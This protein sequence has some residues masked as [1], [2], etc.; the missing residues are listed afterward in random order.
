MNCIGPD[1]IAAKGAE[2]SAVDHAFYPAGR[3][4]QAAGIAGLAAFL[5]GPDSGR[6]TGAAF[7]VDGGV[8]RT[9]IYPE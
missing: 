5:A 1:W 9:M 8:T 3:V 6:I 4:G 2:P 7:I